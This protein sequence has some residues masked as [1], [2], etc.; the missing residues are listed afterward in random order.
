[1]L[2]EALLSIEGGRSIWWASVA[3][4]LFFGLCGM[5]LINADRLF[6]TTNNTELEPGIAYKI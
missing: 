3:L 1:V 5:L 6:N 4:S 2:L